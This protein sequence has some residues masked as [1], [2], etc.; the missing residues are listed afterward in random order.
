[1]TLYSQR[2]EQGLCGACGEQREPGNPSTCNACKEKARLR[3]IAK[4]AKAEA[5]GKC[6]ACCKRPKAD[7]KTKCEQCLSSGAASAKR[8][9]QQRKRNGLC[10][11]CGEPAMPGKTVCKTCSERMT[12]VATEKYHER[13]AQGKCS[14]CDAD[15]VPGSTMC[16]Y[17]LDQ[18]KQQ[19]E[20]LKLE[21]MVA[22]GGA[23]CAWCP[24][25]DIRYLEIDHINGGGRQHV[26]EN[27]VN[28]G[29]GH[30]L[31]CWLKANNFPPGF[32]ILCRT[33]NNKSHVERCR[34]SGKNLSQSTAPTE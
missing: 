25:T 13:R 18:T 17:H 30:G 8:K 9:A 16:Q 6:P 20:D 22:Y 32:R 1:M 11:T 7:G 14:Y 29:S 28:V 5:D 4:R 12:V 2:I 23:K 3:G 10:P 21:V 19:R 33:C 31:R 24:E 34:E 15:P 26:G 27:G